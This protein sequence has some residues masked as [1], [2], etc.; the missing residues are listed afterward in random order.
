MSPVIFPFGFKN[1][2]ALTFQVHNAKRWLAVA[3]KLVYLV[4]DFVAAQNPLI[5]W[6]IDIDNDEEE[7][8]NDDVTDEE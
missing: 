3:T 4:Q 8:E 2:F 1:C 7:S 6:N 5:L